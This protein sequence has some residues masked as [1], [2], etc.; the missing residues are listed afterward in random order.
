MQGKRS[1]FHATTKR[2]ESLAKRSVA[3]ASAWALLNGKIK[4]ESL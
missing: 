4:A 2:D 1:T 3:T